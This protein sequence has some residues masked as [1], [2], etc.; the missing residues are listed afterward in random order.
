MGCLCTTAVP[1]GIHAQSVDAT[2]SP[3]GFCVG[4]SRVQDDEQFQVWWHL[5]GLDY[6]SDWLEKQ[7]H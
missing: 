3:D 7:R 6:Y 5:F 2:A 4:Q 1:C